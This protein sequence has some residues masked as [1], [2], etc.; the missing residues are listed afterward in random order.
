MAKQSKRI[1][2]PLLFA[3]RKYKLKTN[4]EIRVYLYGFT[5][6]SVAHSSNPKNHTSVYS[7]FEETYSP[8]RYSVKTIA[9]KSK[10]ISLPGVPLAV[11]AYGGIVAALLSL[12]HC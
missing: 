4:P 5:Q 6:S 1:H 9:T 2:L 8:E 11:S 7:I 10:Q 12:S 3:T